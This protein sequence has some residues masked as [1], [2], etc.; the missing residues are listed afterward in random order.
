MR[1]KADINIEKLRFEFVPTNTEISERA[2][3]ITFE[4][5]QSISSDELVRIVK[6]R[7]EEED[8]IIQRNSDS[9]DI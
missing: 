6:E 5:I 8:R 9:K 7:M 1:Y 2:F 3:Y 4:Y